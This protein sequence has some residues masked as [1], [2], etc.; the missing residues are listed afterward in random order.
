LWDL[1]GGSALIA[2]GG[3]RTIGMGT[4]P[5][6]SVLIYAGLNTHDGT[7]RRSLEEASGP[8]QRV[9]GSTPTLGDGVSRGTSS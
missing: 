9:A 2:L 7:A 8:D 5:E 6:G 3:E 1:L 4:K